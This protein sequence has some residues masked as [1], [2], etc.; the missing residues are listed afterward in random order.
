[1][2]T[3]GWLRSTLWIRSTFNRDTG[4]HSL[5]PHAK[6]KRAVWTTLAGNFINTIVYVAGKFANLTRDILICNITYSYYLLCPYSRHFLSEIP[7]EVK[8]W[9][10]RSMEGS[11]DD[12]YFSVA[13]FR[14]R[15]TPQ[16][17]DSRPVVRGIV[18]DR[19]VKFCHFTN[20]LTTTKS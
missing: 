20:P 13:S 8:L 17:A 15:A 2:R 9:M 3:S 11:W 1:M 7:W 6:K 14:I 12:G 10:G 16:T 4:T 5:M 19:N 18:P